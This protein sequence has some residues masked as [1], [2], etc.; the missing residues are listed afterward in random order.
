VTL[1]TWHVEHA[2]VV[3]VLTTV[4]LATG[5]ES[6]EAVGSLAVYLAFGHASVSERLREREAARTVPSVECYRSSTLYFVGKELAWAAYFVWSGTYAALVGCAVF[7][8]YPLWRR[9]WRRVHPMAEQSAARYLASVPIDDLLREVR[10]REYDAPAGPSLLS[11]AVRKVYRAGGVWD[12]AAAARA[13]DE[14]WGRV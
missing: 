9:W 12:T 4:W 13:V 14:R 11:D 7:A 1:R 5:H 2:V 6:R 3:A 8:L 10:E